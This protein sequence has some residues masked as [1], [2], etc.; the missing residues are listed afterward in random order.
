M[1]ARIAMTLVGL[2]LVGCNPAARIS[3]G[4]LVEVD[5]IETAALL[6]DERQSVLAVDP[7]SPSRY[8]RGH[9]PGAVNVPLADARP[10]D[11]RLHAADVLVVYGTDWSDMLASAMSKKLLK[12]GYGDVRT[13]R[14][15]TSAW[16]SEGYRLEDA[17]ADAG[18]DAGP[19]T[20]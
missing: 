5:V 18:G 15:G 3:D 20:P 1:S 10:N 8:A 6:E 7:R 11:V 12:Y 14:G 16:V 13:F 17:I 4:D 2:V 9:L 19:V